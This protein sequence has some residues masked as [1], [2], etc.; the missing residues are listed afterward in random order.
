[1]LNEHVQDCIHLNKTLPLP[2][3]LKD[4]HKLCT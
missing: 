3:C 4:E 1:M 2:V